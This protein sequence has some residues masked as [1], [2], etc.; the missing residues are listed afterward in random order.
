MYLSGTSMAAPVVSGTAALLLQA[1]PKLTPNMVKMIL[2]YTA[3]PIKGFNMLEQGTGELNVEGAMRLAKLVRTDL[4][5]STP[6]DTARLTTKSA[7]DPHTTI[8]GQT[9]TWAQGICF[10]HQ[11][12]KGTSLITNYQTY[13]AQGVGLGD[14][15]VLR[16]S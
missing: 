1:N 2:M 9:F 15:V 12:A 7:P 5:S 3:G 8:A 10:R 11:Y 6:Q 16:T 4:S 13:Y 14:E